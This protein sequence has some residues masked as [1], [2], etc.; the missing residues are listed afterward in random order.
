MKLK[1][2][3]LQKHLNLKEK[4]MKILL[5]IF[6]AACLAL[7]PKKA[8]AFNQCCVNKP[9]IARVDEPPKEVSNSL[10][11]ES[12]NL[13]HSG[14]ERKTDIKENNLLNTFVIT[15]D[16]GFIFV[17][18]YF[19]NNSNITENYQT[20]LSN[21]SYSR[22]LK[23]FRKSQN[24]KSDFKFKRQFKYETHLINN[25]FKPIFPNTKNK[26]SFLPKILKLQ[27]QE[28]CKIEK[29][30]F[31][32]C[33]LNFHDKKIIFIIL[34]RA[35]FLVSLKKMLIYT[36]KTTS[37]CLIFQPEFPSSENELKK[38]IIVL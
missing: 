14:W 4:F 29:K 34:K 11:Y 17:H 13:N 28:N 25:S 6:V 10:N 37:Y 9:V 15:N 18:H 16:S 35:F 7:L 27:K 3:N 8:L 22:K 24:F 36:T 19:S 38:K 33:L 12:G 5:T 20:Q 30:I 26:E 31:L 2:L 23:N 32:S 21:Q 1:R